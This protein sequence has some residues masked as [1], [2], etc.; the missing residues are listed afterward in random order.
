M[1]ACVAY[2][3][4]V[5]ARRQA[6]HL[7]DI[8]DK[9]NIV[10]KA[11]VSIVFEGH[12]EAFHHDLDETQSQDGRGHYDDT[13]FAD[14][15]EEEDDHGNSWHIDDDLY[16]EDEEDEVDISQESLVFIDEL[17]QRAE[18]QKRR[19]NIRMRSYTQDEDKLIC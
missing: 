3:V 16:C 6:K 14:H 1:K 12:G 9:K 13:E 8:D 15:D 2:A 17:T 7:A 5:I 10:F 4:V 11:H 18:A 19:K